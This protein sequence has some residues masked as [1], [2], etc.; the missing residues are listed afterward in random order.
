M[1]VEMAA[2][3]VCAGQLLA[4]GWEGAVWPLLLLA[5]ALVVWWALDRA[6]RRWAALLAVAILAATVGL[7]RTRPVLR[8]EPPTGDI[9]TWRGSRPRTVTGRVADGPTWRGD[10]T[11]LVLDAE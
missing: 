11:L 8:A 5:A 10:R 6:Q 9:G 2:V 7:A 4:L 3:G 1:G